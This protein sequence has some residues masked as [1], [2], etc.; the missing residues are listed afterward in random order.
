MK[1]IV[2]SSYPAMHGNPA[3]SSSLGPSLPRR[4]A[5]LS[6][7]AF[8]ADLTPQ[9]LGLAAFAIRRADLLIRCEIRP[10]GVHSHARLDLFQELSPSS[11]V[12]LR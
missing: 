9:K 12:R 11:A 1:S 10:R 3:N 6:G 8:I 4:Y 5:V 7:F 2:T